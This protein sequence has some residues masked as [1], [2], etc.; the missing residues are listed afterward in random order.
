LQKLWKCSRNGD[1]RWYKMPHLLGSLYL[2]R[3]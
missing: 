1:G 3:E 2:L